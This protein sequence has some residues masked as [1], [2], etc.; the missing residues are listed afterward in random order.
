MYKESK[1]KLFFFHFFQ[2]FLAAK[3]ILYINI[4]KQTV[5]F[6][7]FCNVYTNAHTFLAWD[8][9][10]LKPV[11]SQSRI[12][13]CYSYETWHVTLTPSNKSSLTKTSIT[14]STDISFYQSRLL[15]SKVQLGAI[16]PSLSLSYEFDCVQLINTI[17]LDQWFFV[18]LYSNSIW[19]PVPGM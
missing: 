6:M 5:P 16:G 13:Y 14:F 10:D 2:Y 7:L 3:Y 1:G 15:N 9:I 12:F 17:K 18:G 19:L 11:Y 4:P 8:T